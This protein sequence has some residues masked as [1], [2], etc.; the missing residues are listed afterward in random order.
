VA[1]LRPVEIY[2]PYGAVGSLP[3]ISQDGAIGFGAEPTHLQLL[4]LARQI[5]TVTEGTHEASSNVSAI[6]LNMKT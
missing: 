3:W 2:H 4:A 6:R 1:L 5:K